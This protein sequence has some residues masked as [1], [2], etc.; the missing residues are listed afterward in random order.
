MKHFVGSASSNVRYFVVVGVFFEELG[1]TFNEEDICCL[2]PS[3]H[4]TAAQGFLRRLTGGRVLLSSQETKPRPLLFLFL[5]P[6]KDL[7][8][9]LFV[10][11][12]EVIFK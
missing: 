9:L 8:T 1:L 10:S 12:P 6:E 5:Y 3:V 2:H 11:C 4:P 7:W